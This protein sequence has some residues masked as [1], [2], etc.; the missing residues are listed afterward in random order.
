MVN[1]QDI[2]MSSWRQDSLP[3]TSHPTGVLVVGRNIWGLCWPPN[4]NHLPPPQPPPPPPQPP[5]NTHPPPTP[6]T[7]TTYPPPPPTPTTPTTTPPPPPA[8]EC[9][10]LA[11]ANCLSQ[12]TPLSRPLPPPTPPQPP[13]KTKKNQKV[14]GGGSMFLKPLSRPSRLPPPANH[15]THT[16]THLV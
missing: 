6:T 11:Q 8:H 4:L 1:G 9:L 15:H 2:S 16:N 3:S 5:T 10:G 12:N 13:Q 7:P 14:G